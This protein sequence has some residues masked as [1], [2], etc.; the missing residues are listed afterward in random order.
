MLYQGLYSFG[1]NTIPIATG[2][3][4]NHEVCYND[5]GCFRN[6][7]PFDNTYG[8]LPDSPDEINVRTLIIVT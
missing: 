2:L 1:K 5:L 6:N 7:N 3:F 8:E 4:W